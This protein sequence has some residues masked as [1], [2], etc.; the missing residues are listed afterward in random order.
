MHHCFKVFR[1]TVARETFCCIA[2]ACSHRS[3]FA[4]KGFAQIYFAEIPD[5]AYQGYVVQL[6]NVDDFVVGEYA[7]TT[8]A[9]GFHHNLVGLVVGWYHIYRYTVREYELGASVDVVCLFRH[10]ASSFDVFGDKRF[11][12]HFIFIRFQFERFHAF[13]QSSDFFLR[14][15]LHAFFFGTGKENHLVVV[16]HELLH[17]F[18]D[19][20]YRNVWSHLVDNHVF[21]FDARNRLFIEEVA[22][23]FSDVR[24]TLCFFAFV[25]GR[26]YG[27]HVVGTGAFIFCS[28]KPEAAGAFGFLQYGFHG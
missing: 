9:D 18:V 7:G 13:Q 21:E 19:S 15:I 2:N 3:A 12:G 27:L 14:G 24:T 20:I 1:R 23:V 11:V 25:V 8:Q 28:G 26:L 5:S 6:S 16:C 17:D 10:D 22:H 4:G